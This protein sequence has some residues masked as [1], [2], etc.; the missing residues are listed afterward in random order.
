MS[1]SERSWERR[2]ARAPVD[3]EALT[4]LLSPHVVVRSAEPVSGGLVN[5]MLRVETDDG[6]CVFRRWSRGSGIAAVERAIALDPPV[7]VPVPRWLAWGEDWAL[8]AWIDGAQLIDVL[9]D[10]GADD[11]LAVGIEAGRVLHLLHRVTLPAAGPLDAE[12]GVPRPFS[13]VYGAWNW[14]LLE[15]LDGDAGERLDGLDVRGLWERERDRLRALEAPF[16]LCHGDYKPENLRVHGT[17]VVG[18]LDWEFA[19][20][21][22]A[23]C[24][25]GQL[26]RSAH[27]MPPEWERGVE[28]G[29]RQ[30]GG[31]LPDDWRV[32]ARL[33]DLHNLVRFLHG[34]ERP[35]VF[36]GVRERIRHTLAALR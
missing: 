25:V 29:Y 15:L 21:G 33:L 14:A 9:P 6:P 16:V 11:A 17:E 10:L 18:V 8:Q 13:S 28:R 24:D 34:T 20:A 7:G 32:V 22:P 3:L 31:A 12:L 23:L 5:T 2:F 30:A 1:G 35:A 27:L 4:T 36:A 26:L 19:F